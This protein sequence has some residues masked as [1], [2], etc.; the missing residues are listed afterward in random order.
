[1]L[2]GWLIATVVGGLVGLAVNAL[3][4]VYGLSSSCGIKRRG[5]L[6]KAWAMSACRTR[7]N[8][9]LRRLLGTSPMR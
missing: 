2:A 8:A 6:L 5:L 3:L 1:M 4:I 7:S 9:E